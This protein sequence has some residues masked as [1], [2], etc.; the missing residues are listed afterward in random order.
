MKCKICEKGLLTHT[1][2]ITL[3]IEGY[4]FIV[5]GQGCDTCG[6]EFPYEEETRRTVTTKPFLTERSI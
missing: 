6:E 5:K 1:E 2:D 3:E 4:I